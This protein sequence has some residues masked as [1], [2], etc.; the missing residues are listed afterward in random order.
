ML[1]LYDLVRRLGRSVADFERNFRDE[2]EKDRD[3]DRGA[4]KLLQQTAFL[5]AAYQR[6]RA[7]GWLRQARSTS[8]GCE[9]S[10][11]HAVRSGR[12]AACARVDAR[13]HHRGRSHRRSGRPVA[14]RLRAAHEAP[15]A[16]S[17]DI[18][19]TEAVL[20]AGLLERAPR[21]AS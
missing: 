19:S 14:G 18:V 20:G 9:S 12:Q 10:S 17:I 1:G 4:E 15:R 7:R 3:T 2:L 5:A 21:R 16:R 11:H 6:L 8:T 13:R